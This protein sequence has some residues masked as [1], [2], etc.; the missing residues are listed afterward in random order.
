M[1]VGLSI[2]KD[3]LAFKGVVAIV[4][5]CEIGFF[6]KKDIYCS[7]CYRSP[8]NDIYTSMSYAEPAALFTPTN[9]V[10]LLLFPLL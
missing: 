9:S 6:S 1:K 10:F 2:N 4:K 8:A 3:R 7:M 5:C